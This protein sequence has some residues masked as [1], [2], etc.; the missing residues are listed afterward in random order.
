MVAWVLG[1][2][3]VR[4][5]LDGESQRRETPFSS[6]TDATAGRIV[7]R[8]ASSTRRVSTELQAAG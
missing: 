7:V 6:R 2:V 5:A 4:A 8:A 1:M 3:F